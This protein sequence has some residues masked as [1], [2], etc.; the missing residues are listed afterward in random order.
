M[1]RNVRRTG[2]ERDRLADR[3]NTMGKHYPSELYTDAKGPWEVCLSL[4]DSVLIDLRCET[5]SFLSCVYVRYDS[6]LEFSENDQFS[7]DQEMNC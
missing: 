7:F 3:P 4:Y 1:E 6:L 2:G 5:H